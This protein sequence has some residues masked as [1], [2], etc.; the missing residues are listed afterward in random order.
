MANKYSRKYIFHLTG[1]AYGD[2]FVSA[3]KNF[4]FFFAGKF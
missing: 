3:G 4:I 1:W 2:L